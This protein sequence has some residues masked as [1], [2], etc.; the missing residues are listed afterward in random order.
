MFFILWTS[1]KITFAVLIL[2]PSERDIVHLLSLASYVSSARLTVLVLVQFTLFIYFLLKRLD[3]LANLL[4]ESIQSR[5][6][7]RY[8]AFAVISLQYPVFRD[9]MSTI[10][11]AF[12]VQVSG[13][14][15]II[16]V[17]ASDQL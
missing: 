16:S 14:I 9:L 5:R 1:L 3:L 15:L 13:M 4:T 11:A 12:T 7:N 17:Y 2:S 6:L 8:D 10:N